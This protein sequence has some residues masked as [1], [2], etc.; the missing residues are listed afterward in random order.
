MKIKLYGNYDLSEL[1]RFLYKEMKKDCK[2]IGKK[3]K[4]KY[5]K[6]AKKLDRFA[7]TAGEIENENK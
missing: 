5:M 1:F 7:K 4:T 3:Y 6:I 2:N